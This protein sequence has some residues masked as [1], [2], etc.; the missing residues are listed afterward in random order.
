[1]YLNSVAL[2]SAIQIQV[3]ELPI[4]AQ[5]NQCNILHGYQYYY[6]GVYLYLATPILFYWSMGPSIGGSS[7]RGRPTHRQ[8]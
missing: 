8:V 2:L 7:A 6:L 1:M 4:C 3:T 5:A